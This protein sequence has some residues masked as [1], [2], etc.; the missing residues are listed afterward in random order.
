MY[1][2]EKSFFSALLTFI[3]CSFPLVGEKQK[4]AKV[5][6]MPACMR[7]KSHYP[8]FRQKKRRAAKWNLTFK[9]VSPY[10][11]LV[12]KDYAF[13]KLPPRLRLYAPV[14][15]F[16]TY[17]YSFKRNFNSWFWCWLFEMT[18]FLSPA[19]LINQFLSTFMLR[20]DR[21]TIIFIF[22]IFFL[23]F[24][25]S[26]SFPPTLYRSPF[27]SSLWSISDCLLWL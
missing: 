21:F 22:S 18:C 13:V 4:G 25:F 27:R 20:F 1:S 8:S 14:S 9:L 2:K 17:S 3:S 23:R 6:E 10:Y 26:R 15:V 7:K 24:L 19:R 5:N 11:L 12:V 16:F